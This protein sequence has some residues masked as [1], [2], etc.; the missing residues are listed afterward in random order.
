MIS[1]Q[2]QTSESFLDVAESL[3]EA[4][5]MYGS[6]KS[7]AKFAKPLEI[8]VVVLSGAIPSGLQ[9]HRSEML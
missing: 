8:R 9:L 3:G 4:S 7:V 1:D 2:E 6:Q 5:Q